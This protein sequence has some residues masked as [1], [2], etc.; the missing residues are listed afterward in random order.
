MFCE[1]KEW[2]LMERKKKQN[3]IVLMNFEKGEK[4]FEKKGIIVERFEISKELLG[5]TISNV[6]K[7]NKKTDFF[8]Y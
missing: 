8:D 6:L 4:M 2:F 7:G 1:E 5:K 3:Q